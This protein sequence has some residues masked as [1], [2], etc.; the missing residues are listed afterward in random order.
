MTQP[1]R[2]IDVPSGNETFSDEGLFLIL[3]YV[4][5]PDCP[6]CGHWCMWEDPSVTCGDGSDAYRATKSWWSWC[7]GRGLVGIYHWIRSGSRC[8]RAAHDHCWCNVCGH[9]FLVGRSGS[10][11]SVDGHGGGWF[12]RAGRLVRPYEEKK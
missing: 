5:I 2:A 11:T 1:Y 8:T 3:P 10:I 4:G 6:R 7:D 12:T 9:K